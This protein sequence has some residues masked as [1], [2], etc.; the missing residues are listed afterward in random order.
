MGRHSVP[1]G[2]KS[3]AGGSNG[4][5]RKNPNHEGRHR[6]ADAQPAGTHGR[7][8]VGGHVRAHEQQQQQ[9]EQGR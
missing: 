4:S 3:T 9:H 7:G 8:R 1:R 5:P 2:E 6:A